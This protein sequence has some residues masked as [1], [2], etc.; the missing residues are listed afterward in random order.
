[1]CRHPHHRCLFNYSMFLNVSF[2]TP[3][4]VVSVRGHFVAHKW[5]RREHTHAHDKSFKQ[6][7]EKMISYEA[8]ID[9]RHKRAL[10]NP[11][12]SVC[13]EKKTFH[14]LRTSVSRFSQRAHVAHLELPFDGDKY[15]RRFAQGL[16]G[17]TWF[18]LGVAFAGRSPS[19]SRL[20]CSTIGSSSLVKKI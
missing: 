2:S 7:R 20:S 18:S 8:M 15:S 9:D 10:R 3:R 13:V 17:T 12:T 4:F 5:R 19:R 6:S 1:M 16:H 14:Q 11:T